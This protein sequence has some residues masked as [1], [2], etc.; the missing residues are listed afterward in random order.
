METSNATVVQIS[1]EVNAPIEK[2]WEYFTGEQHIV[3]WNQASPDWHCP[4]AQNDVKKDGKF[5]FRME[6]KDGSYGF[7]FEGTYDEV[8]P[9]QL[10]EYTMA[11][12]RKV[13]I[14]FSEKDDH[15]H[16]AE[17]F[18]AENENPVEMQ[19]AG[20]Q[21]ILDSFKSYTETH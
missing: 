2:V 6:A 4:I 15:T 17:S 7:D 18:E 14:H 10:I 3:H 16:V 1:A 20:W 12:G 21:A 19:R 8:Q 13:S 5:K 11:D 9:Q